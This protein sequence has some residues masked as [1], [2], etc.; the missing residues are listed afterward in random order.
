MANYCPVAVPPTDEGIDLNMEKANISLHRRFEEMLDRAELR[1]SFD[2]YAGSFED[3]QTELRSELGDLLAVDYAG[4]AVPEVEILSTRDMGD[5]E[6]QYIRMTAPDG[7]IV[8][9]YK[10]VPK[11]ID[12]PVGAVLCPHGHG[13]GKVI[14]A[15][16]EQDVKGRPIE[17][18]GERDYAVQAARQGYI[19]ISP[20]LRGFGEL[21]LE[22]DLEADL[23]CSCQQLNMRAIMVG[24]TILGMRVY[25]SMCWVDYLRSLE[26]VDNSRLYIT[27]QSGGG[28]V[29]V[30]SAALDPRF[31][32]AAPSCYFC[33]FRASILAMRHCDCNY[34]PGML[35]LCEMYD[36]AGLIAPRP[37]LI[38]A[39]E[40]DP[41]FPI[42]GVHEA[43][44]K[45]QAVYAAFGAENNLELY[46]GPEE[47]R[48]YSA[49]VWDFF[50]EHAGG[51]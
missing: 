42:E 5:Y 24:K 20:E 28:T 27:G 30:F 41:I 37:M 3:W 11:S 23:G 47:H 33:T 29:T 8:P 51:N 34:A 21:M 7:V 12:E 25:D 40:K 32:Q 36:V 22:D 26:E 48:Y 45:L 18:K 17:I 43:Y 15:G 1:L 4:G 6:R 9:A 19:A 44:E 35:D 49:R 38:I 31:A 13:P 2:E 39:G 14:P 16:V 50:V 46:V 10:L